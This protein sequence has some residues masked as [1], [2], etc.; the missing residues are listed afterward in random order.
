MNTTSIQQLTEQHASRLFSLVD[1]NREALRKFWWEDKTR[2]PD[3]SLTYI[4]QVNSMEATDHIPTRGIFAEEL[5]IGVAGLHS[6]D[7]E[8]RR[9]EVGYWI[10]EEYAG[11]GHVKEAVRQLAGLAFR[12]V[13]LE[14]LTICTRVSNKA[15]RAV[16]EG[17]E[18]QLTG[19][20]TQSSWDETPIEVAHYSLYADQFAAA[21]K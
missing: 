18:F 12:E 6:V 7:W 3:D 4:R 8:K 9:A 16:A 5:L 10:G 1:T 17:C 11:R 14:E 15:S 21:T 13:G 2:S 20:D 19:I